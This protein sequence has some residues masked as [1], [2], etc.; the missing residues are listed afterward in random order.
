MDSWDKFEGRK[1]PPK[2]VFYNKMNMEGI[3]D[4]EYK[5]ASQV[6]NIITPE[7]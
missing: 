4:H 2:N 1:L 6:L 5:H 3:S 7:R